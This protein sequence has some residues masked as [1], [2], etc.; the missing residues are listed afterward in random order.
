MPMIAGVLHASQCSVSIGR[1]WFV[2]SVVIP[3]FAAILAYFSSFDGAFVYDDLSNIVDNPAIRSLWPATPWLDEG[4]RP[5]VAF[6]LALN[7][8]AG[9]LDPFGYHVVN[10]AVHLGVVCALGALVRRTA[11]FASWK[12]KDAIAFAFACSL[13]FAVHPLATQGVTYIIQRSE[14]MMALF[15]LLTL[16]C[17]SVSASSSRPI[18]WLVLSVIMCALGM[19][20]KAVMITAPVAALFY[21]RAFIACSFAGTMRTRWGYYFGLIAAGSILGFWN[22]LDG[23]VMPQPEFEA[24]V[25]FGY[26]G[27]IGRAHV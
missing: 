17:L 24:T 19:S 20:S 1:F 7:Y 15:Y 26:A 5:L 10:L 23:I 4:R 12:K 16:W 6:T 22:V 18:R 25:G 14:S 3:V 2:A 11:A 8:A 9:G 27:E 13:I 21:D